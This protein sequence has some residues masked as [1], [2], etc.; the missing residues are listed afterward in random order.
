MKSSEKKKFK[1]WFG[2]QSDSALTEVYMLLQDEYKSRG[3]NIETDRNFYS[4]ERDSPDQIV[5]SMTQHFD[6]VF[7]KHHGGF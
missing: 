3:K 2:R 1:E 6:D 4:S 7:Y 5:K